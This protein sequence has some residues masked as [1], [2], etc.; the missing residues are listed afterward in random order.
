M[1]TDRDCNNAFL[2]GFAVGHVR[3]E[4]ST[5]EA[6]SYVDHGLTGHFCQGT[7]DGAVGDRFRMNLILDARSTEKACNPALFDGEQARPIGSCYCRACQKA[8]RAQGAR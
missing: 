2:L 8:R 1:A 3:G 6:E 4:Q 7:V 5:C